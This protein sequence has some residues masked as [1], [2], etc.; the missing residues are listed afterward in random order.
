M[1]ANSP[2]IPG[3]VKVNYQNQNNN[4][5]VDTEHPIVTAMYS[6]GISLTDDD[7]Y[8]NYASHEYF[9]KDTL[10]ENTNIIFETKAGNSTLVEYRIGEG[11]VIASALTWES[12]H[13]YH[14]KF[15]KKALDDLFLYVLHISGSYEKEEPGTV[16]S[17]IALDQ[18]E[19]A[20]AEIIDITIT[21]E[22]SAFQRRVRGEVLAMDTK[23]NEVEKIG[24]ILAMDMIAGTPVTHTYAWNIPEDILAGDYKVIVKWYDGEEIVGSG[25][26]PFF[27]LPN[28]TLVDELSLSDKKVPTGTTVS[29]KDNVHNTS[30]NKL[31]KDLE[32]V[33]S[34]WDADDVL[35]QQFHHDIGELAPEGEKTVSSLLETNVLSEG[36]YTV[37]SQVYRGDTCVTSSEEILWI[38]GK[39]LSRYNLVG[40]L[41]V[42]VE[43]NDIDQR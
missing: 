2:Y 22:L 13:F 15:G 33:L 4:Y 24:D 7:M 8:G 32:V 34:V 38:E 3:D 20:N 42:V 29:V 21:S 16:E 10:P 31:D 5:I 26:K 23:G 28:G 12:N 17:V 27:V 9:T 18:E 25:E 1:G 43:K 14:E 36:K 39:N 35:I 41:D 11:V 19:Y 30:T 6:D 40:G 37:K